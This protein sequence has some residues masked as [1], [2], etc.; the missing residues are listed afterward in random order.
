MLGFKYSYDEEI[1]LFMVL[2]QQVLMIT[3]RAQTLCFD[4]GEFVV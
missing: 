2:K 1:L 3:R 4:K